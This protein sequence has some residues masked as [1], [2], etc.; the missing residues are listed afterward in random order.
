MSTFIGV[1]LG[2]SNSVLATFDGQTV[3]VVP[4]ALGETLTP[5][6]VRID[7]AGAVSVGRR[8]QRQRETDPGNVA[9]AWKRLM[10]TEERLRF[11][12]AGLALLPEELSAHVVG[13]L[14]ADARDALGFAP[15]GAVISTPALFELPQNHATARAGKLAGLEEVVLIQEPIAG[16]IAAGWRAETGERDGLWLVI[17]LGGGTLDVSLLETREGRLRVVDH[18]GDNFLGGKDI[19]D[20]LCDWAAEEVARRFGVRLETEPPR[21]R[22][23]RARLRA[24]CEQAKIELGRADRAAVVVPDLDIGAAS[25]PID[26]ELPIGRRE[27][28]ALAAPVVARSLT[29]VRGM[30]TRLGRGPDE[31]GRVVMVGGSTLLPSLRAEVGALFGG[32]IAAGVDPM[33]AVA[34]GAALYAGTIGLD[35][36][37]V[38]QPARGPAGLAVRVEHPPV[39]ADREPFV[40]GRF[41]PGAGEPLPARIAIAREDAGWRSD[42]RDPAAQVS[43]EG[44]FVLQVSLAR[45]QRN[46]FRLQAFDAA[47]GETPLAGG[48][49]V[50]VHGL[51]IADPPLA[52]A[53]GVACA[54]DQTQFYFAKG[55]PLPARRTF[56]HHTVR[57]VTAAGGEDLLAIPV[58]QGESTRSHRNRLIGVLRIAGVRADLAAGA[59]VEVT[60]ELDRS[61]QLHARADVPAL[62]QTFEEVAHVL[63][64]T[65][66][67][68]TAAR[69]IDATAARVGE[70][71][72]RTFL[73][74]APAAVQALAGAAD[75]LAE[76]E[77]SL[78]RA[79]GGD[80]DAA[81][82]LHRL[83]LDLNGALDDAEAILAWPELERDA[84][85]CVVRYTPLVAAWGTGAEQQLYEQTLQAVTAARQRRDA[86][87]LERQLDAL[88]AIGRAAY[89]RNPQSL[90]DELEWAA[91]NVSDAMDVAR[92]HEL[93]GRARTAAEA[94]NA[95]ALRA[96]MSEI[97][98]L[99]PSSP[100]QQ[101]RSFGSGVR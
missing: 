54:D 15:R 28:E 48:G 99:F 37:P 50:I 3:A 91:A 2:T 10:G 65:A 17:D 66:T 72:R 73:A 78:A 34:R 79:R 16:A 88:R 89:C 57:P 9:A 101:R 32:R 40:V 7:A 39:T 45:N 97:W 93:V 38:R 41:L 53:V 80:A 100:E 13:A 61:G 14:L 47:G 87:E 35:A 70:L 44:S 81:H 58:V 74:G 83:L 46:G 92:A 22:R 68:A 86:G 4:N 18:A 23:A 71:Q 51:S 31:V 8:A 62:G 26:L 84:G 11:E 36:R 20:A 82:K 25:G 90:R 5:S 64:P 67:L 49:F 95:A 98:P 96:L 69:E 12:A 33:T 21:H 6:V 55:T 52:R 94:G 63:V 85:S 24:A 43:R 29:V 77:S 42:E 76:A 27:L 60:L 56:V 1:D 30:L 59:R 19:D 75:L